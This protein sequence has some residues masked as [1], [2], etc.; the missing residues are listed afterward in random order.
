MRSLSKSYQCFKIV[1]RNFESGSERQEEAHAKRH[2]LTCLPGTWEILVLS[3]SSQDDTSLQGPHLKHVY[4]STTTL[5]VL[6]HPFI[7][8]VLCVK[9]HL[10]AQA[11]ICP[12]GSCLLG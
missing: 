2:T 7:H 3:G 6:I 10:V 5:S 4:V 1:P 8:S 9:L 12:C 11:R